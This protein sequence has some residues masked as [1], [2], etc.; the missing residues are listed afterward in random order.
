MKKF[1]CEKC[2][3][4]FSE[5]GTHEQSHPYGMGSATEY[6]PCCPNCESEDF[7]EAVKCKIC[8]EWHIEGEFDD[9]CD[10]CAKDIMKRFYDL[11][12]ENFDEN[13]RDVIANNINV[14]KL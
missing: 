8:G 4:V 2:G 13:E 9:V 1:I 11:V 10:N 5:C 7:E 6:L 14:D 12:L 3:E